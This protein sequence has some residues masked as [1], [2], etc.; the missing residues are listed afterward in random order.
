MYCSQTQLIYTLRGLWKVS[1]L[2]GCSYK[3]GWIII[4]RESV[5]AFFLQGQSTL[6]VIMSYIKRVSIK[7]ILT[8]LIAES[9]DWFIYFIP[10]CHGAKFEFGSIQILTQ[11]SLCFCLFNN[12]HVISFC[13]C[14]LQDLEIMI[15]GF[16]PSQ[17]QTRT[18]W[19]T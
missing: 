4:I 13:V 17:T 14:V 9:Q 3:V 18:F 16:G 2:T 5:R 6:S 8:V 19:K 10:L 7:G 12:S 11:R 1:I 15:E